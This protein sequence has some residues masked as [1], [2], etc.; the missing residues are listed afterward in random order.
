MKFEITA[1]NYDVGEK[2]KN[3]TEQKLSKLDKYFALPTPTPY[4]SSSKR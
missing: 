4:V 1:R 3:V 2:L